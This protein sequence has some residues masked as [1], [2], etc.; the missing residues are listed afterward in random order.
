M[1]VIAFFYFLFF[2]SI[3]SDIFYF[4]FIIPISFISSQLN[5]FKTFPSIFSTLLYCSL[6]PKVPF[7]FVTLAHRSKLKRG[8]IKLKSI[9]LFDE[10]MDLI[11][12]ENDKM[13]IKD[14]I[15]TNNNC[16]FQR[17]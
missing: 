8:E 4:I 7:P 3:H 1:F 9:D 15:K 11:L 12:N 6:P 13:A 10:D 17:V 16:L 14:I 2:I 5:Y